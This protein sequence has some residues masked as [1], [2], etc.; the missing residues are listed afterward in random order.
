MKRALQH[1]RTLVLRIAALG[2][3]AT[4]AACSGGGSDS[5]TVSGNIPLAYVKRI[6]TFRMDPLTGT[7]GAPGGDL[8]IRDTSS[9]SAPE[10]N[11]TAAFTQGV[12]DVADPEVSYDGKKLVFAMNCPSSNTATIGGVPACTG[13]WNI[14][15]YDMTSGGITGG[16]FRRIT[17]SSQADD[18][19]PV[20]LRPAAASCSPLR[21]RPR[22][23]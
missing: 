10:H 23:R 8:I 12:G 9:A 13:R 1:H 21:A 18:V 19:G 22:R 20:Y 6:N 5:T 14:W 4:L 15:E 17:S 16:A 7:P 2:V 11:I 3:G